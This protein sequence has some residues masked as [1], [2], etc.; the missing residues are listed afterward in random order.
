MEAPP[1]INSAPSRLLGWKV[2]KNSR[3]R[4]TAARA[5]EPEVL[6]SFCDGTTLVEMILDGTSN[7]PVE[8]RTANSP[9]C[10]P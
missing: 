10:T 8:R 6:T 3:K 1:P 7:T 9:T 4:R 5:E 2:R